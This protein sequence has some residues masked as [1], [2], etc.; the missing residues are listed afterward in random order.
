[1]DAIDAHSGDVVRIAPPPGLADALASL[2]LD[3]ALGSL[4]LLQLD[5]PQVLCMLMHDCCLT[6]SWAGPSWRRMGLRAS[7][8]AH[9][10]SGCMC[11]DMGCCSGNMCSHASCGHAHTHA[12]T[13]IPSCVFLPC[14]SLLLE[15]FIHAMLNSDC[16]AAGRDSAGRHG[17]GAGARVGG[18]RVDAAAGAAGAAPQPGQPVLGGLR[19][20]PG[21]PCSP[22]CLLRGAA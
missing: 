3:S 2:G 9:A 17:G 7:E 16:L 1:M 11:Y 21:T 18:A 19:A 15:H 4:R 5:P 8:Q 12:F 14:A 10:S 20:G 22:C 6:S 13:R